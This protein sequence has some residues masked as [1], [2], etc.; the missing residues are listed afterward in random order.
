MPGE[1]RA[2][3]AQAAGRSAAAYPALQD[4]P[5]LRH[6]AWPRIPGASAAKSCLLHDYRISRLLALDRPEATIVSSGFILTIVALFALMVLVV[7]LMPDSAYHR[8]YLFLRAFRRGAA[9]TG[10]LVADFFDGALPWWNHS[11]LFNVMAIS[12]LLP[13]FEFMIGRWR[14]LLLIT[15]TQLGAV[16]AHLAWYDPRTPTVGASGIAFGLIGFGLAYAHRVRNPIIRDRFLHWFIYGVIFGVVVGANNAAHVGGFVTG[17]PLGYWMAG[18]QPRGAMKAALRIAGMACLAIWAITLIFLLNSIRQ[19]AQ[20]RWFPKP[21]REQRVS[22]GNASESVFEVSG[23]GKM[24]SPLQVALKWIPSSTP[25]EATGSLV[26]SASNEGAPERFESNGRP[27]YRPFKTDCPPW[28]MN[29][30]V[31]AMSGN[32]L[33]R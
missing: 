27:L 8:G 21:E 30:R 5:E 16:A 20:S 24:A 17:L 29:P 23:S 3:A 25:E 7:D 6:L 31:G 19:E 32:G 10:T 18:R 15:L 9:S 26:L 1:G 13:P 4:L 2:R 33:S 28:S 11:F 22:T 12:Q 14:T